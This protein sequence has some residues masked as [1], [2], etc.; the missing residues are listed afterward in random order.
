M[1]TVNQL[2]MFSRIHSPFSAKILEFGFISAES[3]VIGRLKGCIGMLISI[4][5]TLF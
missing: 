2:Q 5:T 4:I 3:A 1:Q